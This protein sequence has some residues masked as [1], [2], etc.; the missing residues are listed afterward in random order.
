M[1]TQLCY[2]WSVR[3]HFAMDESP[4]THISA[5]TKDYKNFKLIDYPLKREEPEDV[6]VH[7]DVSIVLR[8]PKRV[9]TS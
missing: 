2:P 5:D 3:A 8:T 7:V 9:L 4:E 1:T 6:T